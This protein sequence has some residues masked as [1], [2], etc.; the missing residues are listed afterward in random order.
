MTNT[1]TRWWWIRHAPVPESTS[2]GRIYGALD[3]PAD[4]TDAATFAGLARLLPKGAV[5]ATSHL[6][7][8]HQTAAAI[9]AAGLGLP[10]PIVEA[11]LAEQH[12]GDWQGR[13][14]D[15]V[16]EE[17]GEQHPFWLAPAHTRA[18]NG[19]SFIDVVARVA[20]VID[21]LTEQLRG[22]DVVAVAH[23]GTI[24]A[25][26]AHT[27]G[28]EPET[29]LAFRIDNCAVTRLDHHANATGGTWS[30]N[31]ANYTIDGG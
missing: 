26:I 28:L 20:A 11:D 18:P 12:L 2:G 14:A 9:Q 17:L 15:A 22:R 29:A 6:Q 13:H 8:T 23:G 19:E 24:R 1:T 16:R 31:R 27:L 3:M 5:L 7:R 30:L 4:T 25:A 21:R 10:E